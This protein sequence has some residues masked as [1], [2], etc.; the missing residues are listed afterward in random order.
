M[1]KT[2]PDDRPCDDVIHR[3]LVVRVRLFH[4]RGGLAAPHLGQTFVVQAA[5]LLGDVEVPQQGVLGQPGGGLL[6]ASGRNRPVSHVGRLLVLL[7]G[8]REPANGL[9]HTGRVAAGLTLARDTRHRK[10][11]SCLPIFKTSIPDG[12]QRSDNPLVENSFGTTKKP[13]FIRLF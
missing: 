2:V 6:L 7:P 1:E 4:H 12:A 8:R 11:H 3:N 10:R 9:L 13:G 5:Q